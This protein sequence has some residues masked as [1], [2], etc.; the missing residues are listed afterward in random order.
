M[1]NLQA[2]GLADKKTMSEANKFQLIFQLIS[3]SLHK[4]SKPKKG[5]PLK[6]IL[7]ASLAGAVF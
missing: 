5:K 2:N 6:G 4:T 7:F 3:M 1:G